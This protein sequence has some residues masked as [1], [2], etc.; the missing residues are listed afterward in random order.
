[1]GD[2]LTQEEIDL[3]NTYHSWVYEKLHNLVDEKALSYLTEATKP[4]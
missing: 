2:A 4:L 3:V 1:M